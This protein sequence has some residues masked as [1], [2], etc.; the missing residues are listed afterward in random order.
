MVTILN[1]NCKSSVYKRLYYAS[2]NIFQAWDTPNDLQKAFKLS[3]ITTPA[4]HGIEGVIYIVSKLPSALY[5]TAIFFTYVSSYRLI[6]ALITIRIVIVARCSKD[7]N[8]L[9]SGFDCS[10]SDW[11]EM[12]SCRSQK[13]SVLVHYRDKEFIC[14]LLFLACATKLVSCLFCSATFISFN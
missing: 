8:G 9:M 7:N 5:S 13:C 1:S 10:Q 4:T 11:R 2:N 14:Q 6:F 12:T 3:V